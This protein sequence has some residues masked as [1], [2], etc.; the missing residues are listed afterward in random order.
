M[1]EPTAAVP[2]KNVNAFTA[3]EN[4]DNFKDKASMGEFWSFYLLLHVMVLI[5]M[6]PTIP[7]LFSA[8]SGTAENRNWHAHLALLL[9]CVIWMVLTLIPTLSLIVRKLRSA[10]ANKTALYGV[11][12]IGFIALIYGEWLCAKFLFNTSCSWFDFQI[13]LICEVILIVLGALPA[14]KQA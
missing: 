5:L 4:F 2:E 14:K 1:S 10:I 11:S 13:F 9:P 7:L 8:S 3:F 6:I 12:A